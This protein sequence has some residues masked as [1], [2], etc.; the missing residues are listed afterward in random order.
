MPTSSRYS[1]ELL[2]E[3]QKDWPDPILVRQE[4]FLAYNRD[5]AASQISNAPT[6]DELDRVVSWLNKDQDLDFLKRRTVL[7]PSFSTSLSAKVFSLSQFHC[8]ICATREGLFP[9][10]IFPIRIPPVS[11]QAMSQKK[12][13]RA[14]FE[15]AIK[16]RFSK[17]VASFPKDDSLCV[18]IV[19]VVST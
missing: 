13:Y 17:R 12:G 14:A 10:E 4:I 1:S 9:V 2:A 11:K 16:H 15:L 18:M 19:F 3:L 8:P 6:R 5:N 7:V